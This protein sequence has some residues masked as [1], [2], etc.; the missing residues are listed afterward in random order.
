MRDIRPS[1]QS[2]GGAKYGMV[3]AC[4]EGS[5]AQFE[6]RAFA[7]GWHDY[8]DPVTGSLNTAI[9]QWLMERT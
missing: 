7:G 3:S 4:S 2:I 6:L 8:E 5:E 9:A 1:C